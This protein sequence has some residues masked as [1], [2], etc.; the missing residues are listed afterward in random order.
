MWLH[1]LPPVS[2]PPH[3]CS[4]SHA[5]TD[6]TRYWNWPLWA[7]NLSASPLF[8]GSESS[9]SGD[10]EYNPGEQN[11]SGG[12]ITIPRGSGGGC[13]KSGPFKDMKVHMGPFPPSLVS[14]TEIPAPRFDYN[15]HCLNRSLN[16][17]VSSH[18][19]NSTI[20]DRLLG[21]NTI[22]DFQMVMDH[23]PPREDGVLG[24]H[25]GGHFSIGSTLQDL[26]ASSQDPAF[27]LH[28]SQ[29]DRLWAIW[30]AM[31]EPNR[32]YALNGTSTILNPPWG[33]IVRLDTVMEF[34]ILDGRK[35]VR[36]VMSPVAGHLCYIYS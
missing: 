33:K 35:R 20:V 36:E 11:L 28:H 1:R 25:G 26:F 10:G 21:S 17:F 16:N 34:G 24:L 23:W 27:F 29:I 15:P 32:R 19:T 3:I 7:D 30:Q 13:A 18:Y 12:A 2:N 9:L 22:A 6:T 4:R 8:D 5:N 14:L 31:D